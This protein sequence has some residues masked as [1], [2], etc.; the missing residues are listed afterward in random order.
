MIIMEKIF[1][2]NSKLQ[3]SKMQ[4]NKFWK[5][6]SIQVINAILKT[7]FSHSFSKHFI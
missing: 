5:K 4:I 1:M 7:N 6:R 3:K 2:F